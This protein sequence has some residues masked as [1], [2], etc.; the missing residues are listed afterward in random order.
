[1]STGFVASYTDAWIEISPS[2]HIPTRNSVA[3]YTD[4]WIEIVR[5][6]LTPAISAC[7]ILHG[8]VD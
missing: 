7:R 3:S 5:M 2:G 4:A 6:P 1:M 8:C